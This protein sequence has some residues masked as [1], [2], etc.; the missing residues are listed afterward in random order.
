MHIK[1]TNGAPENYSVAQLRADN[2]QTSFPA[3]IPDSLLAEWDVYPL[4]PTVPP[5]HDHTKTMTEGTP[6][7]VD[8][9]WTQVWVM[10]DATQEEIDQR[11]Q[12][13]ASNARAERNAKLV[14]SDWT[15]VADA[16]VDKAAWAAYRQNL[17]DVTAQAGFPWSIQWP[18]EPV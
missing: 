10:T 3:Q 8:G 9:V 2:P 11:T 7:Q 15:Q 4:T 6:V 12:D 14:S 13:Q 17:R 1:L 16:P 5:A 18:V